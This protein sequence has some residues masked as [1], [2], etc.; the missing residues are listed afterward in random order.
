MRKP[1]RAGQSGCTRVGLTALRF[2]LPF[3]LWLVVLT[4][5]LLSDIGFQGMVYV[6]ESTPYM[7]LLKPFLGKKK[8]FHSLKLA[9]GC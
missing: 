8:V 2:Q 5:S 4:S 9:S 6:D 3:A 1:V 7:K